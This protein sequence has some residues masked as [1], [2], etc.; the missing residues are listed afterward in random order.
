MLKKEILLWTLLLFVNNGGLDEL[1]YVTLVFLESISSK[2]DIAL[3]YDQYH[4]AHAFFACFG[5]EKIII[6]AQCKEELVSIFFKL[7]SNLLMYNV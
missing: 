1:L 5:K 6:G 7:L 3:L 2:D 4:L